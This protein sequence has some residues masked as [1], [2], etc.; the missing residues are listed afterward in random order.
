[1][2]GAEV[3]LCRPMVMF[4]TM[5]FLGNGT[6]VNAIQ[7]REKTNVGRSSGVRV[8]RYGD[9]SQQK[10]NR[11]ILFFGLESWVKCED[12]KLPKVFLM[13][14]IQD[15][16]GFRENAS[17]IDPEIHFRLFR[18]LDRDGTVQSSSTLNQR[19]SVGER[20]ILVI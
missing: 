11:H 12:S 17:G 5:Q 13:V 14:N 8:C 6:V 19:L 10:G 20:E 16:T 3:M 15:S 9:D 7:K 18:V 1:M 2:L 4:S